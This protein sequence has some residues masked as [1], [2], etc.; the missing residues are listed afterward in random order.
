[1]RKR[2]TSCPSGQDTQLANPP[3]PRRISLFNRQ[4]TKHAQCINIFSGSRF[5]LQSRVSSERRQLEVLETCIFMLYKWR[6]YLLEL[7]LILKA[8]KGFAKKLRRRGVV[9]LDSIITCLKQGT[10]NTPRL[11]VRVKRC[12]RVP[13]HCEMSGS[14]KDLVS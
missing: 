4:M 2:R 5:N 11:Q 8:R 1:M 14:V 6:A 12:T 3:C 7:P 9:F 13:P 10:F